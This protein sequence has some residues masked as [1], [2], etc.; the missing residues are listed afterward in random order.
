[1]IVPEAENQMPDSLQCYLQT[2]NLVVQ[3]GCLSVNHQVHILGIR[4]EEGHLISLLGWFFCIPDSFPVFIPA[5]VRGPTRNTLLPGKLS[6]RP[7]FLTEGERRVSA[8]AR[9]SHL[10]HGM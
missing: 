3:R 10:A 6:S 2:L 7:E 8:G 9:T 5:L 1:M 4:G